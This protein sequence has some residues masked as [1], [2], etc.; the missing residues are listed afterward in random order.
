[1]KQPVDEATIDRWVKGLPPAEILHIV[2]L[3]G[4]KANSNSEF[5]RYPFRSAQVPGSKPTFQEW[6]DERYSQCFVVHEFPTKDVLPIKDDVFEAVKRCVLELLK[7]ASTVVVVDS[8]GCQ[9][10]ASVCKA[11]GYE[12]TTQTRGS[13]FARG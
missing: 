7:S 10:S 13:P 9:R 3:L 4:E 11:I 12:L 8:A 2:S 1:M 5:G 6:L